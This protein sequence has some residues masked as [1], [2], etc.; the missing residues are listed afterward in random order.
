MNKIK[1]SCEKLNKKFK[2]K[3]LIYFFTKNNV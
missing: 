3:S 2:I 1:I